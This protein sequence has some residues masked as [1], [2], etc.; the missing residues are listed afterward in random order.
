MGKWWDSACLENMGHTNSSARSHCLD[1]CENLPANREIIPGICS[2]GN[3]PLTGAVQDHV[4][5]RR[6]VRVGGGE[7]SRTGRR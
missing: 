4:S 1:L 5:A 3:N 2:R 7:G 6:E